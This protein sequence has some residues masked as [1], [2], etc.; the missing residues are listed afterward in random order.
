[1][2]DFEVNVLKE[3]Y[4]VVTSCMKLR[5]VKNIRPVLKA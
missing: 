1:M 4:V 3:A 5:L 2:E